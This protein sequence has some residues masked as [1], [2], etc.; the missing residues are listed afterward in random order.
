MA[1][2]PLRC[3]AFIF[4][5]GLTLPA[6]DSSAPMVP[7]TDSGPP[8]MECEPDMLM[9]ETE[10]ATPDGSPDP[11]AVPADQSRAGRIDPADLP[12]DP[13]GLALWAGGDFVLANG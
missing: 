9:I 8:P 12:T 5:T 10:T 13:S 11:L 1:M 7:F 2:P 6:C 3:L 4:V